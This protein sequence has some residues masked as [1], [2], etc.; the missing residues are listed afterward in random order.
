MNKKKL[1]MEKALE[2]FAEKGFDSTSVQQITDYCGISKGAF[3]LSFKSKDELIIAIIEHFTKEILFDID[4]SVKQQTNN[5]QVIYDFYI[6]TLKSLNKHADFTKILAKEPS[7]AF[8]QELIVILERFD[9]VLKEIISTVLVRAYRAQI[10]HSKFDLI[11]CVNGFISM[12]SR[13]FLYYRIPIDLEALANSLVEKTEILA[14]HVQVPFLTFDLDQFFKDKGN[15]EVTP[16]QLATLI[17]QKKTIM[18]DSIEKESLSLLQE[19]LMEQNLYS[20]AIIKGL[21]E[22]I[23]LH[24]ECKDLFYLLR[25]Y[26]DF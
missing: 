10:E 20:K 26:F 16:E 6:T 2:L 12:Y 22:N 8:N 3:Y 13:L 1:I 18:D 9:R 17:E 4:Q 19:Q 15:V 21:C 14:K 25:I 11:Y 5:D 24:P 23:R 7:H